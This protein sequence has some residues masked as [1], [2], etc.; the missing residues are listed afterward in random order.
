[1]K[2]ERIYKPIEDDGFDETGSRASGTIALFGDL[3]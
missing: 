3:Y 1:M 2:E